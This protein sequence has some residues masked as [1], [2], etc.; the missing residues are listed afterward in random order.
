MTN[1]QDTVRSAV[2]EDIARSYS[3]YVTNVVNALTQRE[4]QI[5][6]RLTRYAQGRGLSQREIDGILNEVGLNDT[7]LADTARA[8]T[9]NASA[10]SRLA[11]QLAEQVA[12]LN[13][14]IQN[15]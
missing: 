9:E 2:G 5:K 11:T 3:N 8:S 6:A 4:D 14:R 15:L 1:I 12:D 10:L 13:R 7:V